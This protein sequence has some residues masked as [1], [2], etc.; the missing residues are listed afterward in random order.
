MTSRREFLK[1]AAIAGA[2]APLAAFAFVR[3][4]ELFADE[5][6]GLAKAQRL[7]ST[8]KHPDFCVPSGISGK[9]REWGDV[10]HDMNTLALRLEEHFARHKHWME[11]T[12]YGDEWKGPCTPHD[13][14]ASSHRLMTFSGLT[15]IMCLDAGVF[16]E[17][18]KESDW[19]YIFHH[20]PSG[21]ELNWY[22]RPATPFEINGGPDYP[23]MG[24][25]QIAPRPGKNGTTDILYYR[26]EGPN[27]VTTGACGDWAYLDRLMSRYQI[28][29]CVLD[30]YPE[31]YLAEKFCDRYPGFVKLAKHVRNNSY[32][33]YI[34][35]QNPNVVQMNAKEF[36][37][38][39]PTH[40][41][42]NLEPIMEAREFAMRYCDA[43]R[44]IIC[45]D[46]F[47]SRKGFDRKVCDY[48]SD[49]LMRHTEHEIMRGARTYV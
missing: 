39:A 4:R 2:A 43:A 46:Y 33:L 26:I 24:V 40:S 29:M 36:W 28:K 34:T 25:D 12:D 47:Y 45:G 11:S 37:P 15:S 23:V 5:I 31:R 9:H 42:Y 35:D 48:F 44:R 22:W 3:G 41:A 13:F 21:K 1:K 6:P 18:S 19:V 27:F 17:T 10:Y 16:V 14:K 7:I 30:A 8:P 49:K 38:H 20:A 32:P